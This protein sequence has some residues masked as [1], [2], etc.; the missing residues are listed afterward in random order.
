MI[1]WWF[2]YNLN[3]KKYRKCIWQSPI[4]T[5]NKNS[6]KRSIIRELAQP[7]AT[8]KLQLSYLMA[9]EYPPLNIWNKARR[10]T[11]A[12]PIQHHSADTR[13]WKGQENELKGRQIENKVE[14]KLFKDNNFYV[15]KTS[16]TIQKS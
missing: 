9:R 12:T 6:K 14:I 2:I 11:L 8:T 4:S 10:F 7:E 15:K 16:N 5:P 1:Y 13:H 3:F